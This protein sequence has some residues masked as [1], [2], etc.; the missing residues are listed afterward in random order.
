M[1]IQVLLIGGTRFL[2]LEIAK[3]FAN[4]KA[5]VYTL[6]RGS[7]KPSPVAA[8]S[9]QCDKNDREAFAKV[10]T[11]QR[12]DVIV[13]TI[14][15]AEDL[16]FVVET[17]GSNVGHFIHT[18]SLG[19][20]GDARQI[21]ASESQ[22]LA[23]Y[24][25][26]DCVVFNYKI[27]QDQVL[28][29]AFVEQQFPMTILRASYICG[30]GDV[31]LDG[32][33]GRSKD[34]FKMLQRGE[35]ILLPEGGKALLHPGDVRDLGRAFVHAAQR[36]EKSIGQ[37]Y[38]MGGSHAVMMKDYVAS[39]ARLMGSSS[40]ISFAPIPEVLARYPEITNERG[41][42]FSCQHMCASIAKAQE[43]LNWR[44]EI[45]LEISLRDSIAWMKA[46]GV[47]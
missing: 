26:S 45:P 30:P 3:A 4:Q 13:D 32:W 23:E 25:G 11:R 21:P 33:G 36:P 19:V 35:P 14:L 8:G 34:F 17:V 31:L 42:R 9:I 5:D 7:H 39:I 6:N 15:N 1:S 20:Y 16:A 43:E 27:Q 47:C 10:L 44:P 22:P 41:M 37:V 46:Q 38:N 2:G 28:A 18:G 40:E 12:W 24:H 29:R